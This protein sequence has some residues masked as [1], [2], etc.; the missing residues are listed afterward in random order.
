MLE[1]E[2]MHCCSF[3]SNQPSMLH[4]QS[5]DTLVFLNHWDSESFCGLLAQK[6]AKSDR[7]E[8]EEK[9]EME[10]KNPG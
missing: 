9:R 10:W 4:S 2:G 1:A 5:S 8:R 3:P 6:S 7:D